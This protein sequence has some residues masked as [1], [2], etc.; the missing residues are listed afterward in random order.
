MLLL[1]GV[2]ESCLYHGSEKYA[3]TSKETSSLEILRA[4]D[5]TRSSDL[6]T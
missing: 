6:R 4:Y 2:V 5:F 3:E 1:Q